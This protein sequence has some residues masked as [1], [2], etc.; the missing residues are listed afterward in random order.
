M[1]IK[2]VFNALTGKFDMIDVASGGGGSTTITSIE[3]DF[4]TTPTSYKTFNIIDSA[5]SASSSLIINQSGT[6]ATGR[7][8]DESEMDP[9]IF[10]GKAAS[11][12]FTLIASTLNGPVVGKYKV[13]YIVG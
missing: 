9:I 7:P 10:A 12:S 3:V 4:G 1:A 5:V 2:Y 6:P 13:N 11:G 8:A